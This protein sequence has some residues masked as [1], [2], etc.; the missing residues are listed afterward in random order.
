MQIYGT[1]FIKK[2]AFLKSIAPQK[3]N[4][5]QKCLTSIPLRGCPRDLE[6]SAMFFFYKEE[7][8]VFLPESI[9][10]DMFAFRVASGAP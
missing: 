3:N 4:G 1:V 5:F 2:G 9:A 7:P 6:M 10:E 8:Q